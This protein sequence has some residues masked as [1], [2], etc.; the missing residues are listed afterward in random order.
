MKV[1][2]VTVARIIKARGIRG[3]VA[4][5]SLTT[6]LDRFRSLSNAR[7]FRPGSGEPGRPVEI[8]NAWEHNGRVI[9]K[10]SG[11]DTLTDAEPLAGMELRVPEEDRPPAPEGEYYQSE[12]IGCDLV[13]RDGTVRGRVTG[14]QNYGGP[15]L[16]VAER[17]GRQFLVPFASSICVE[18]DPAGKRITVDLPEGLDEL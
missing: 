11:I 18:I 2:W 5:E 17:S 10:V 14:W 8:E 15:D 9:L 4:V 1:E 16:L 13:G 3:E 6:G 7:L 12:L